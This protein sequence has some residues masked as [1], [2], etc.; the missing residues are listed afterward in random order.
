VASTKYYG[1]T[2]GITTTNTLDALGHKLVT[3]RI[4]T[5]GSIITLQQIGYDALGRVASQTNALSGVTISS[6][7]LINT[8]TQLCVSNTLP[9]GGTR[10]ETYYSD[11]R[12][13]SLLGTAVRHMQYI[14]GIEQDGSGGPWVEFALAVKL[15]GSGGTNEWGKT[16][17]DG[18]GRVYKAI[19][20]GASSNSVEVIY[21]NCLGQATNRSDADGVSTIYAFNLKGQRGHTIVDMNQDGYIDWSG[22]DRII[23]NTNDVRVDNGANVR[24]AGTFVYNSNSSTP[25]LTSTLEISTD[26]LTIWNTLWNNGSAI[27]SSNV[28]S[29]NPT[30]G[31]RI[32]TSHAPDGSYTINTNQYGRS[33]SITQYDATNVSGAPGAT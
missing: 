23:L 11:G 7:F 6:N 17:A 14:Y 10:V 25:L 27:T 30:Y 24:W 5:N 2:N 16:Y 28:T 15:T 22:P 12:L 1:G 3:Q 32:V 29:F 21:Y 31:Y 20:P 33:I 13:Q 4:G 26:E 8:N 9:D 19:F 18:V